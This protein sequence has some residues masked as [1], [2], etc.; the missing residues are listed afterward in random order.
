MKNYIAFDCEVFL[1]LALVV[2]RDMDK[3]GK[4]TFM[5][6][7]D[8]DHKIVYDNTDE[9]LPFIE[10]KIL[11]SYNGYNYDDYILTAMI[12]GQTNKSIKGINDEIIDG[13]KPTMTIAEEIHSLDCFRQIDVSN[14]SLKKVE[15]NLG[16]SIIETS[17]PF[18]LNRPLTNQEIK[19][20]TEY[21]TYDVDSTIEIFKLRKENYFDVKD[22]LIKEAKLDSKAVR[23]NTTTISANMLTDSKLDRYYFW[24]IGENQDELL[25]IVPKE[26]IDLWNDYRVNDQKGQ[27]TV[28]ELD[29]DIE[30]SFGALH[31]VNADD[32]KRF[33]NVKLLD[34]ASLYP[35][36]VLKLGILG[37]KSSK[38][39]RSILERRLAAKHSGDKKLSDALKLVI[40]SCY[41]LLKNEYSILYNPL[42]ALSVCIYG[43]VILYD[44]CKRLYHNGCKLININTDGIAFITDWDHY[45]SIKEDWEQDYGFTLEENQFETFI[46]KDVN[47][48]IA[49]GFDGK[50]KTKGSDV[51]KYN[52]ANV[53]KNNSKRIIDLCIINKLLYGIDPIETI[54]NN[55]DKPE[56][57]Q[58]VLKAGK[59]YVG[60]VDET[61]NEYQ[62]VNR[63]FASQT[64]VHLFKMKPDGTKI[65]F[66]NSPQRMFVFNG[67]LK[68]LDLKSSEDFDAKYYFELA[69]KVLK[70]WI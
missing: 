59:T 62:K 23:W 18:T 33:E 35:N 45:K 6:Q 51:A 54:T 47:N 8:K 40:N 1:H 61:G 29:C 10:D 3:S 7:T 55:L 67:D 19:E 5:K 69:E 68:D 48:Y 56:L 34:V 36:I 46:Q 16:K 28:K 9:I 20:V 41:G 12:N 26:A 70:R 24:D 30:F 39:Y 53:F 38:T 49:V 60:T 58:I 44:L 27:I 17:V 66:A 32:Q 37:N 15:A 21:C 4:W 25:Q 42:A 31:G 13:Y 52:D 50:V 11:V 22:L 2:F 63:V 43:Q 14:P 65:K 57:F 64:G